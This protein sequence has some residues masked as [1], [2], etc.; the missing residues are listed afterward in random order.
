M[1]LH[2]HPC[3]A[4]SLHAQKFLHADLVQVS[5]FR[6]MTVVTYHLQYG[7]Y[8]ASAKNWPPVDSMGDPNIFPLRCLDPY[9]RHGSPLPQILLHDLDV[10]IERLCIFTNIQIIY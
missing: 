6:L 4:G 8:A 3:M 1:L 7:G 9:P 10:C 2:S 5:S